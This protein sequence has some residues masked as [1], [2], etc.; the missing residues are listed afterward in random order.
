MGQ[1]RVSAEINERLVALQGDSWRHRAAG[2]RFTLEQER[3]STI[4]L[5]NIEGYADYIERHYLGRIYTHAEPMFHA[6]RKAD[7]RF[8]KSGGGWTA[9][10][11]SAMPMEE[12]L[13]RFGATKQAQYVSGSRVYV[14]RS[15]GEV[16]A[17][18]D[19]DLR[20]PILP[21]VVSILE[22]LVFRAR[23]EAAQLNAAPARKC[24]ACDAIAPATAEK[25]SAPLHTPADT[26]GVDG[27][28]GDEPVIEVC[29]SCGH[30]APDIAA[31]Y[32]RL[33]EVKSERPELLA[34]PGHTAIALRC[35]VIA[36]LFADHDHREE[37]KW[38][39]RAAWHDE[40][41]GFAEAARPLRRRAAVC[42]EYAVYEGYA[43]VPVRSATSLV[44]AE[45]FRVGGAFDRAFEHVVRG[46]R[47]AKA[48][49]ERV[50]QMSIYELH[51]VLERSRGPNTCADALRGFASLGAARLQELSQ[52]LEAAL[53]GLAA[54]EVQ[55][56][57]AS[58]PLKRSLFDEAVVFAHDYTDARLMIDLLRQGRPGIWQ[59]VL[60]RPHELLPA[61]LHAT[62]H[63]EPLVWKHALA[64]ITGE[65]FDFHSS[66]LK[67]HEDAVEA[68]FRR[69]GEAE[70]SVVRAAA[71]VTKQILFVDASFCPRAVVH[72]RAA[73]PK[74]KH[75]AALQDTLDAIVTIAGRWRPPE[76]ATVER[77]KAPER[78][79][80]NLS[81]MRFAAS[82][83]PCAACGKPP[84]EAK[85]ELFGAKNRFSLVGK[86]PHCNASISVTFVTEGDPNTTPSPPPGELG[87]ARPSE[88][89]TPAELLGELTRAG[90][91]ERALLCIRELLKS[92]PE[93][94]SGLVAPTGERVTPDWLYGERARALAPAAP[95]LDRI[96]RILFDEAGPP[97]TVGA[98]EQALGIVLTQAEVASSA[99]ARL[100]MTTTREAPLGPHVKSVSARY[101]VRRPIE[102]LQALRARPLEGFT[103]VL[104]HGSDVV[105]GALRARFGAPQ[106][107]PTQ[108][109]YHAWT[110]SSAGGNGEL[111]LSIG[112]TSPP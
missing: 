64:E 56:R 73:L 66:L 44:I 39:L 62:G 67:G 60:T 24:A 43:L 87:D 34:L 52:R 111:S 28:P 33:A 1:S 54:N 109:L 20:P 40:A 51:C 103:V 61:L 47:H 82:I 89:V 30:L 74:W 21:D 42:L 90:S 11:V 68:V 101:V 17:P 10:Q 88:F 86:C 104:A 14:S 32:P 63:A 108:R 98:L 45:T 46:L 92:P 81:E 105:E 71:G 25:P 23:A 16:P 19:P 93:V 37:G 53:S 50:R 55:L 107:R 65:T 110:V 3:E 77:A 70:R 59:A 95:P 41:A 100:T 76:P 6:A 18:F 26:D 38:S 49:P 78:R 94:L 57:R 97:P 2:T 4:L 84:V 29:T 106:E 27:R 83:R 35:L 99:S 96:V 72:A 91:G 85:L 8:R 102:T 58:T 5:A 80:R 7:E 48:A 69:M 31:D 12:L 75:D 79:G 13:E 36:N 22:A 15:V 9:A 112:A